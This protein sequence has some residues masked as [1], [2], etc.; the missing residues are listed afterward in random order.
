MYSAVI[1]QPKQ[2]VFAVLDVG[3][4]KTICLIVKVNSNFSYK[5]IEVPRH[6]HLVNLQ[7]IKVINVSDESWIPVSTTRMTWWNVMRAPLSH[8]QCPLSCHSQVADT[9]SLMLH[10]TLESGY[11]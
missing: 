7:S 5:I 2:N 11:F 6:W 3:T 9:G 8:T 1:I 10:L 4:T